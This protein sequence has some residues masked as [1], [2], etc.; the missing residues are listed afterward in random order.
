[1]QICF[2]SKSLSSAEA[3][4]VEKRGKKEGKGRKTGEIK[5][6]GHVGD[7]SFNFPLPRL[8][9]KPLRRREV[10]KELLIS[11]PLVI[12]RVCAKWMLHHLIV[13][14]FL[15]LHVVLV[16]NYMQLR[17]NYVS[18]LSL[19]NVFQLRICIPCMCCMYIQPLHVRVCIS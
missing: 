2:S 19:S 10:Q 15:L 18:Y 1:M 9:K 11:Y 5:S 8:S 3:P 17:R 4:S 12:R 13:N 6:R 16:T 14:S 7:Y